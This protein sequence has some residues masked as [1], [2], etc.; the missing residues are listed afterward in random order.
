M[1]SFAPLDRPVWNTLHAGWAAHSEGGALA[2]RIDPLYGP[3][4]A[5]ADGSRTA[6]EAL[7]M[8]VPPTGEL[9]IVEREPA[10]LPPGTRLLRE[11][12]LA[13]MV[14]D[15]VRGDTDLEPLLLTEEDAAEMRAL[16]LMTKPGPFHPL[17][18]RL[19]R[20]IGIRENGRLAA[21]AGERMRLPGLAEVS[22]V[23][24]HPDHRG[25]GH[26]KALMRIVARAMLER[27]EIPFLHAYA[28]HGATI[29]LYETLGFRVRAEMHMMVVARD[30]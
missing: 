15:E 5:A 22:G 8:L 2:C 17:T 9:W 30:G 13:Q 24:T 3:F 19:G 18:H 10:P 16:A 14:A 26:A 11:A 27:D 7:A 1:P 20:F 28:D 6:Q 12:R 29:A 4:G 21:M 23:C 25:R